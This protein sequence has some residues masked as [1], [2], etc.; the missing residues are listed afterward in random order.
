M[1]CP[2]CKTK[3]HAK[4]YCKKHYEKYKFDKDPDKYRERKR[5]E[6]SLNK[7]L[8]SEKNKRYRMKHHDKERNRK[9]IYNNK[10]P[11]RRLKA[12][13][14]Q[15]KKMSK[16]FDMSTEKYQY[17][18]RSWSENIKDRDNVCQICGNKAE[19]SHHIIHKSIYPQLSLN[20]NNGVGLCKNCHY[21][22][23]GWGVN[24]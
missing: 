7:K 22:V 21:E 17:A 16:D 11:E 18:R 2:E 24:I 1:D 13:I 14:K 20:L 6:Y 23:H 10:Y 4:G 12:N 8:Y 3:H 9:I 15:L 19:I 5:K